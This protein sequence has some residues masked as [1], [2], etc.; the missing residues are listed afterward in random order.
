MTR[1]RAAVATALIAAWMP[2]AAAAQVRAALDVG[3]GAS[4]TDGT[5]GGG[6]VSFAPSLALDAG[7]LR[8]DAY[9]I[10][11]SAS[12]GRW[13]FEGFI[14]PV[15]R[16]PR[17]GPVRAEL[18]GEFDWTSHRRTS[19]TATALGELRAVV[20]PFSA[21][22]LWAGYG[23]GNAYSFSQRRP[24]ARTRYGGSGRVGSLEVGLS[25]T[26]TSFDYAPGGVFDPRAAPTAA[27][28]TVR[29]ITRGSY[30]DAVLTGRWGVASLAL[31]A[32]V[33]RRM[34]RTTPALTIWSATATKR[35][36]PDLALVASAGRAPQDP[37]TALPG[38]RYFVV[39]FR[40]LVGAPSRAAP[41]RSRAAESKAGRAPLT[42]GPNVGAGREILLRVS[43]AHA[44]ELRG[45]FTDWD[46][47]TLEA[48]GDE[49]WRAVLPIAT[50]LHRMAMRVDGGNWTA[51]PG[52]H[53]VESEFGGTVGE[54]V[55]EE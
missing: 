29:R 53:P 43:G 45:D 19:G 52:T 41:P 34:S 27:V 33:G 7:P 15:L 38:S 40:V 32:S 36:T 30:T 5:L 20:E 10:Y 35:I 39:G 42:I 6:V 3:A 54:V 24:V 48:A 23:L 2:G 9:G 11:S 17:L 16:S 18:G 8:L 31:D 44:V 14:A 1:L 37:V 21:V 25:L 13:N 28:D 49:E 46:P 47:V 50:G 55:V 12:A 22:T 26:A 4:R 51:P